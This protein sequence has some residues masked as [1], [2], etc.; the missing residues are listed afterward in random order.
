MDRLWLWAGT[1]AYPNPDKFM[2]F[3]RQ[4]WATFWLRGF[5]QYYQIVYR[6]QL[7]DPC[8]CDPDS[9]E[10]WCLDEIYVYDN[11]VEVTPY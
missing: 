6:C 4:A 9:D 11:V 5:A 8:D 10:F 3:C 2:Y 7:P 1:S